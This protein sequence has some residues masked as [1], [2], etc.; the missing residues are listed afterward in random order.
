MYITPTLDWSYQINDICLKANRKLAVLRSV[1]MLKRGTLDLL[2]KITVRSVID[3]A[4]P[5][6]GNN[7]KQSDLARLEQLQYRAAKVVTGAL[8]LTSREKL[9]V[10]LGWENIKTRIKFLGLCYF[11]KIHLHESRPLIRSCLTPLDMEKKHFTRSKGGYT[12]YPNFGS[13]YLNSFFPFISKI[14]NDLDI[15][16]RSLPLIDFKSKM[17]ISLKPNKIKH[18]SKGSKSG[19]ILLTR[20]RLDR[21]ELN[22]H[23]FIIGMSDNP[24]CLCH[25]KQESSLHFIIDC[26]LYTVERQTLFCQVEQFVPNFKSL[27]KT[28]QYEILVFGLKIENPDYEYTNRSISY[29]VQNFILKTKRFSEI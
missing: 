1:K 3:Y 21:S 27:S 10:E 7:L 17:K 4:L 22:L 8:H 16:T 18:Y 24:N 13:R 14:W 23:K 29:A 15:T 25:A 5:L 28:K 20:I 11:H 6:Y 19:N 12:P 26:F 2:Y 9:N